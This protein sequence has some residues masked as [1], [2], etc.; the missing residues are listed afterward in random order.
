MP[1]SCRR[2]CVVG[3]GCAGLW[4]PTSTFSLRPCER[5]FLSCKDLRL[6]T[7]LGVI[8]SLDSQRVWEEPGF[9]AR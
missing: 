8:F 5:G 7:S 3:S 4:A 9:G 2:A 6:F 1:W